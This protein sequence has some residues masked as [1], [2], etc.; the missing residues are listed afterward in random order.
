VKLETTKKG[1]YVA[2]LDSGL[3]LGLRKEASGR[4]EKTMWF[5]SLHVVLLKKIIEKPESKN[6]QDVQ[7]RWIR[8]ILDSVS[9]QDLQCYGARSVF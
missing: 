1:Y 4:R 9:Q 2:L 7:E 3:R 5:L 8:Q 6:V